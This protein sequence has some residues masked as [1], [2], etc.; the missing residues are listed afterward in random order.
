M[1][2]L[3]TR[4]RTTRLLRRTSLAFGLAIAAL[5]AT[6]PTTAQASVE[7]CWGSAFWYQTHFVQQMGWN[8]GLLCSYSMWYDDDG[9]WGYVA[10]PFCR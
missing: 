7:C 5:V 9:N 8:N 2:Q 1:S 3:Q 6:P 10:E 4:S